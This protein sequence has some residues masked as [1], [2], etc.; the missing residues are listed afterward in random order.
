MADTVWTF[1]S[2]T[3][4]LGQSHNYLGSDG[5]TLL[6]AQAFGP[7]GSGAG[8]PGPVQLFGKNNGAD[9]IG[10]G[11]SNDPSGDGEITA[12]SFIQ[13]AL[14]SLASLNVSFAANSTTAGESW[15]VFGSNVAG[16]LGG[17][18]LGSCTST[19]GSGAGNPCEGL[20]NFANGGAF[21]FVDVTTMAA[22]NVNVREL[23]GTVSVPGPIVGAGL[24]GLFAFGLL[25]LA[26]MRRWR[27]SWCDAAAA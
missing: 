17:R 8:I 15:E 1:G 23:D 27:N 14:P 9:E 16:G 24:P 11:L 2:P 5:V 19:G 12:G 13:F 20:F 3:S 25:G 7:N 26:R 4:A 22:G 21:K 10:V 18:L 6:N